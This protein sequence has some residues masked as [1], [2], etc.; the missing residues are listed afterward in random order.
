MSATLDW[1]NR[2]CS[3]EL[4]LRYRPLSHLIANGTL[5]VIVDPVLYDTFQDF[6]VRQR[7]PAF[8]LHAPRPCGL[9]KC[10]LS[11]RCY[12]GLRE[13][14][15]GQLTNCP[16]LCRGLTVELFA[17]AQVRGYMLA[18]NALFHGSARWR[19]R[20]RHDHRRHTGHL[21]RL[22]IGELPPRKTVAVLICQTRPIRAITPINTS[23]CSRSAE[24][25]TTNS[26]RFARCVKVEHPC[27][28]SKLGP[29]CDRLSSPG[30]A[31]S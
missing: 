3:E 8:Y 28:N 7:Y 5:P 13:T 27:M 20:Y 29:W 4:P 26:G 17:G 6:V 22:S 10:H 12:F 11:C 31:V 2:A 14:L 18:N 21:R 19:W 30:G 25:L 16:K 9:R 23:L 1:Q 24:K 15:H